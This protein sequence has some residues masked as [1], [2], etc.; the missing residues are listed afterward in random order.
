MKRSFSGE[1]RAF[2]DGK[3]KARKGVIHLQGHALVGVAHG[4]RLCIQI[5]R[6]VKRGLYRNCP[7]V[8]SIGIVREIAVEF[9]LRIGQI[10]RCRGAPPAAAVGEV[11]IGVALVVAVVGGTVG[12]RHEDAYAG[13][14]LTVRQRVA[15]DDRLGGQGE[16]RNAADR[17][18]LQGAIGIMLEFIGL[19]AAHKR[20]GCKKDDC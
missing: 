15:G 13:G 4:L 10:D 11:H 1:V 9:P 20:E 2:L 5:V 6:A 19:A 8:C 7:E 3:M 16:R 12:C 18:Y 17:L 14:G